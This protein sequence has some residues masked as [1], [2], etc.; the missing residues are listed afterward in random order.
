MAATL[1][2]S[3][4]VDAYHS[5]IHPVCH[6][7]FIGTCCPVNAVSC[8]T[9]KLKPGETSNRSDRRDPLGEWVHPVLTNV[10]PGVLVKRSLQA[11]L[12]Y[13]LAN[14]GCT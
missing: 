12:S 1:L 7:S 3:L 11:C 6:L 10:F 2:S 8:R 4:M 5:R 9:E 14:L 13:V